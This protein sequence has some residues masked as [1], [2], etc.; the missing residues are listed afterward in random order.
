MFLIQHVFN[1]VSDYD[2]FYLC[3]NLFSTTFFDIL[4]HST[5]TIA[6]P[7]I[8]SCPEI[9]RVCVVQASGLFNKAIPARCVMS[10]Y[11]EP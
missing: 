1:I 7:A 4:P 2:D 3:N 10:E 11:Y 9:C 6:I 5:T 8:P